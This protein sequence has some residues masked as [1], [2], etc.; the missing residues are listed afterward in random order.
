MRISELGR[1]VD[2]APDL[3]RAWERRYGLLTPRRT[4]HNARLYSTI[5][6]A[7]VRMMKRYLGQG[8]A[9]A[10]AAELTLGARVT[11]NVGSESHIADPERQRAMHAIRFALD[12]F[13]ETAA[14]LA[15]QSVMGAHSATCVIR[16][17]V[18]PYM[19]EIGER[20]EAEHVTIAQEHFASNF[21]PRASSG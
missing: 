20:W 1:R 4:A 6:E 13:D 7:R 16:D 3:L 11:L 21:S 9:A 17:L 10:Q 8:I 19:R 18:I 12:R 2:V 5:D 15:L 14:Q